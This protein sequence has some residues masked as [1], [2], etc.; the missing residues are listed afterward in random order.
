ML[1]LIILIRGINNLYTDNP[2]EGGRGS[3]QISRSRTE[4]SAMRVCLNRYL[5]IGRYKH[6]ADV[7]VI[8]GMDVVYEA[9][10][11]LIILVVNSYTIVKIFKLRRSVTSINSSTLHFINPMG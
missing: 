5:H 3:G 6:K 11:Y 7:V 1:H 2:Q 8:L 10:C 9:I 4:P